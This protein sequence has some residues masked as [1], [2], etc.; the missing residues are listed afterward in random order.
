MFDLI[1][2]G[3]APAEVFKCMMA[4]EPGLRNLE[5]GR[6]FVEHFDKVESIAMQ[7]ISNWQAPGS[8]RP[9]ADEMVDRWLLDLLRSAGYAIAS[10]ARD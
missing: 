3:I 1:L 4:A 9:L 2:Q 5:L 8:R 7:V 10:Q 6:R